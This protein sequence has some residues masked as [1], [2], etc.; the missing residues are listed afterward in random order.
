MK[1]P[2]VELCTAKF[3]VNVFMNYFSLHAC[4]SYV[5]SAFE[6]LSFNSLGFCSYLLCHIEYDCA[7]LI[8]VL[9]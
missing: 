5:N 6:T 7:K 3:R 9:Y 2:A 1:Y 4:E 8:T